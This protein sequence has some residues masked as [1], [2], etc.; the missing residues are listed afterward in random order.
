MMV[1]PLLF[2]RRRCIRYERQ[3]CSRAIDIVLHRGR[4]AHPDRPDNFSV[5]LDR[6]PAAPR[7][8]TR[9]RGYTGKKGRVF[10]DKVEEVLRLNDEQRCILLVLRDPA[11]TEKIAI[12]R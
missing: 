10:L 1:A 2:S 6:K 7:R 8:P 3:G 4:S 5:H 9:E 11:S 12:A